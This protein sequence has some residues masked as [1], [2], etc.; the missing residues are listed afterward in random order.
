MLKSRDKI[1]M[2][3]VEERKIKYSETHGAFSI[4]RGL[5]WWWAG[6]GVSLH[7]PAPKS[8]SLPVSPKLGKGLRKTCEGQSPRTRD[9]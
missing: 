4:A 7:Y 8:S 3:L 1:L 9:N 2:F 5:R 6:H